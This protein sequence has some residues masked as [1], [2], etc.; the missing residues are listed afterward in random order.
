MPRVSVETNPRFTM[1]IPPPEKARLARAA[2]L[3]NTT[4]KEFMLRNALRAADAVI[5]RAERIELSERDTQKILDLLDNPREPNPRL[6]S[7]LKAREA[8]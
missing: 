7:V 3:E 5:E 4:M 2:T 6:I 1:E 8:D